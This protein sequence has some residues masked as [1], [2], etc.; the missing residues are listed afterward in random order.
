MDSRPIGV[1]DSGLGGLSIVKQ[2]KRL[3]PGEQIVYFGDT[4][5]VPYGNRSHQTLLHYAR[6]D[7]RFLLSHGVKMLVAA[8]GTIST[9]VDEGF[10]RSLPV[11][12][13]GVVEVT[14]RAAAAATQNSRVGVIGTA[15]TVR[16]GAFERAVR[17]HRPAARVVSR[18]CPLF[19]PLVENGYVEPGNPVTTLVARDYLSFVPENKIDT[20]ILGCTHFPL[21]KSIIGPVVGDGV[22]LI[23]PGVCVAR[24]LRDFLEQKGMESGLDASAEDRYYVSDQTDDFEAVASLFMGDSFS[25]RVERV[26]INAF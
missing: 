2:V 9:T 23:D 15:A 5:R 19:I 16:S 14:A 8:C 20:L 7:S 10:V 12:Y 24:H 11:P 4:A 3:L 6:Q 22:K 25:G 17:G 26:D 1:F 21:L 13:M 18:P